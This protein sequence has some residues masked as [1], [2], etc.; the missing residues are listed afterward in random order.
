MAQSEPLPERL[1][2]LQPFREF[3][4]KLPKE[5][6]SDADPTLLEE[7]IRKQ[8]K[9]KTSKEAKEKLN[10]D[11][12]ELE[13]YLAIPSRRNDR[14]HF[15][16]GYFLI[17]AEDPEELL[18]PQGKPEER[19]VMQLPPKAKSKYFEEW[20][21]I[22][23]WKRQHFCASP[24][25][26]TYEFGREFFLAQL[27]HPKANEYELYKLIGEISLAEMVHPARR[28]IRPPTPINVN[29]GDVVGHKCVISH[30]MPFVRKTVSYN[31]QIPGGYASV[32]I[33]AKKLFDE[34]EWESYLATLRYEKPVV[35]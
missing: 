30:E 3:L 8:I 11:L 33:D 10:A 16:L 29:L 5:Q 7:L 22:V 20:S 14:L 19:L 35:K 4:E 18:K 24:L 17:A 15:V 23:N 26:M 28:E 34:S 1:Q 6:A 21:L 13:K 12:E 27:A 25:D 31:L 9:G 32:S 2:Y